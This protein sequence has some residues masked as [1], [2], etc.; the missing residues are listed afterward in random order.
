MF[1]GKVVKIHNDS[2]SIF[3]KD[4]LRLVSESQWLYQD[5]HS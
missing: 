4:I 1:F 5:E 2:F 3:W